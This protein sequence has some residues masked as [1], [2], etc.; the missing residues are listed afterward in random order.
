MTEFRF[1][2]TE[3]AHARRLRR[4]RR[5]TRIRRRALLRKLAGQGPDEIR[6][7]MGPSNCP[8]YVAESTIEKLMAELAVEIQDNILVPL[9]GQEPEHEMALVLGAAQGLG[10]PISVEQIGRIQA[11]GSNKRALA[12]A[13]VTLSTP[14]FGYC[15]QGWMEVVV[16]GES[17]RVARVVIVGEE[18][19]VVRY[20][21]DEFPCGHSLVEIADELN[22]D[23][24]PRPRSGRP[25]NNDMLREM[26]RNPYYAGFILYR[27]GAGQRGPNR[28][29]VGELF[30]GLHP[31]I[32]TWGQFVA[33]QDRRVWVASRGKRDRWECPWK[34]APEEP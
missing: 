8:Y 22:E 10:L 27:G 2:E 31:A 6:A 24:A 7:G 12:E 28:R 3:R 15:K 14:P 4:S 19:E 5:W 17:R 30:P 26:I 20:V 21:F 1:L 11:R 9:H 34:G 29:D 32:I 16:A 18:A 33:A 13:G 25:W 23:D